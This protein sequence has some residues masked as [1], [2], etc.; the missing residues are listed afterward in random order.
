[1]EDIDLSIQTLI[2]VQQIGSSDEPILKAA[3][4]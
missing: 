1:M 3:V 4:D 2:E